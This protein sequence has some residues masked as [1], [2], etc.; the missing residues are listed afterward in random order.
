MQAP[1]DILSVLHDEELA[2]HFREGRGE[3]SEELAVL[4]MVIRSE[5]AREGRVSNKSI[6]LNLITALEST[7]DDNVS[8]VLRRTLGIVVGY[9]PDDA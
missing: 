9:T 3:L 7:S 8:D 2:R 6:I 1:D 5:L 4:G